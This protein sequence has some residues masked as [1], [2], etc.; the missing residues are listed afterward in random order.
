MHRTGLRGEASRGVQGFAKEAL[1]RLGIAGWTQEKFERVSLS[2]HCPIEIDPDFLDVDGRLIHFPGVVAGF[3]MGAAVLVQFGCILLD[4]PID[5][6]MIDMRS[7]FHHDL[8]QIAGA[9]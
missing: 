8:F 3:Q 7:P 6:R 9:E 2:I 1:G 4:P 5:R